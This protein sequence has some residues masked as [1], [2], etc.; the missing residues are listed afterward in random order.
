[1]NKIIFNSKNKI[2]PIWRL[3]LFL[4]ITFAINIPLQIGLQKILDQSLFR[5]YI[6]GSIYFVSVLLSLFVQIKY[7]DKSSFEKY[8][9]KLSK[10]WV[11]EFFVG[12]AF[13]L[14]QLSLFFLIMYLTG[15]L[16]IVDYFT[17]QSSDFT[18]I[19][20][21]LSEVF[22]LIIG[23]SVEEIFF[24]A[25]LFYILYEVLRNVKKD[26]AKRAILVL[27][28]IS[29][30]FGI[31][32]MDNEGATFVSTINLGLYG[33]ILCLPF[34]I[35]GRLGMSTGMHF[36]WNLVQGV[37]FGFAVSGNSTK[38]SIISVDVSNNALTG[39]VFGPEGSLL[40]LF[41]C[42]I[43]VALLLLWKKIKGY[44]AIVNPLL[45]KN[46]I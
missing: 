10:K 2:R 33:I 39:G 23:T 20:G 41:I 36:S 46:D 37:F 35:T 3:L 6:S 17:T 5:G 31:A 8:G 4:F 12:C 7:L 16:K 30:V 43:A 22:S 11:Q 9:L 24:R 34:L 45:I 27:F 32:H 29:I 21:F 40:F 13:S 28:I 26:P 44:S 15:N 18:F 38:V 25:F 14:L 1:M 19:E 42:V